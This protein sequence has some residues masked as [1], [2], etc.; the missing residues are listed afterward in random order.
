MLIVVSNKYIDPMN[1]SQNIQDFSECLK[2]LL[3]IK[4]SQTVIT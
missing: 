1:T 3:E 2:V 4:Y